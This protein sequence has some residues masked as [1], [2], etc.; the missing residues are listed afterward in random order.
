MNIEMKPSA[1]REAVLMRNL[2]PYRLPNQIRTMIVAG[3]VMISVGKEN[4]SEEI[5]FIPLTNM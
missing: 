5:G 2:E 1:N 3:I 4:A